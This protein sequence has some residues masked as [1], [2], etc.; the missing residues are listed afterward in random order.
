[1]TK[2]SSLK[3]CII[4]DMDGVLVNSFPVSVRAALEALKGIG[5]SAKESDLTQYIGTG[6]KNFILGPCKASGKENLAPLG[7]A[8]FYRL[9]DKYVKTDL[10]VFPSVHKVLS[11]LKSTELKLALA[12]S[13]EREKLSETLFS[14]QIPENFFDVIVSGSDVPEKKPNPS[15][16]L[17]TVEELG[18]K[19][20]DCIVV[21]DALSGVLAAK[22]ANLPCLTVSTSFSK[23]LL[24]DAGADYVLDDL[25][26]LLSYLNLN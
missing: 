3:K 24:L 20:Q 14:A 9:F 23:P 13:S 26:E 4:F 1:M 15:I 12:S 18:A 22:S 2:L 5:I 6:E 21:E 8:E 19:P 17:K 25:S 7:I 10:T 11:A 16:Y